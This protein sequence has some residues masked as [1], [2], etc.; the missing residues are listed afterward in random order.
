M[1]TKRHPHEVGAN[2]ICPVTGEQFDKC[3]TNNLLEPWSP[4]N[5]CERCSPGH[6]TIGDTLHRLNEAAKRKSKSRK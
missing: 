6:E 2:R 5:E 3:W 4:F 1:E